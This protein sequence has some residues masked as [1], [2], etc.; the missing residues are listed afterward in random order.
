MFCSPSVFNLEEEFAILW[1]PDADSFANSST[2]VSVL[3][4][5]A[6][7]CV[8]FVEPVLGLLFT[9]PLPALLLLTTLSYQR[10]PS[11]RRPLGRKQI[12]STALHR[13]L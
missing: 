11:Q 3:R 12:M 8:A 2:D 9:S 1:T 5:M 7:I 10:S 4:L 6:E 13:T